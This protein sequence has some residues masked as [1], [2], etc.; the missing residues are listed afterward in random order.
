MT[1]N[2]RKQIP[3]AHSREFHSYQRK[4]YTLQPVQIVLQ[5]EKSLLVGY[6]VGM[7]R[8]IRTVVA[9]EVPGLHL[10]VNQYRTLLGHPGRYQQVY[11]HY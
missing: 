1:E 3:I 11:N 9:V 5:A 8:S 2:L 4:G 10:Q 7:Q 6:S